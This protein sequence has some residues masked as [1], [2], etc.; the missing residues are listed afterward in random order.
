L[1]GVRRPSSTTPAVSHPATRSLAG[2]VPSW[3][4]RKGWLIRSN[5]AARSASR[6]HRRAGL[7]PLPT[8]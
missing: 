7:A 3:L 6:A 4:S 1:V 5:A 2:N 8:A